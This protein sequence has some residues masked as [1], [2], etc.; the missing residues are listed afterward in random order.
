[1]INKESTVDAE[2]AFVRFGGDFVKKT[3]HPGLTS[4][5]KAILNRK[6]NELFNA[7]DIESARRI[8][9]ATG[10]SDGITRIGDRYLAGGRS[11]DALKMYWIAPDRAK[12]E[13]I[14]AKLSGVIQKI[15]CEEEE[16]E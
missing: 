1:M 7:G 16:T 10:Y 12:A 5:E 15:M 13:G 11:I 14:I 3:S 6:G 9:M 2:D 8:F 4:A